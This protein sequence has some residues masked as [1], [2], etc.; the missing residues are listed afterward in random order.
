MKLLSENSEDSCSVLIRNK[1]LHKAKLLR[2]IIGYQNVLIII[3]KP[4]H[5]RNNELDK[6][7]HSVVRTYQPKTNEPNILNYLDEQQRKKSFEGN[8]RN[9]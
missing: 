5:C 1:T 8:H 2:V 6:L 9:V 4:A 7:I 3:V